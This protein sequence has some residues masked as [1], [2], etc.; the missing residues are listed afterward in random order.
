[1]ADNVSGQTI[2]A[3]LTLMLTRQPRK[4][5]EFQFQATAHVRGLLEVTMML[6][7]MNKRLPDC[8]LVHLCDLS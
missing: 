3:T 5:S 2:P 8:I 1:M 6:N 4:L 7:P